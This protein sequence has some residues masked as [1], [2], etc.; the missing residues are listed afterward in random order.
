MT[1]PI[2]D[3][4]Q[5]AISSLAALF[6]YGALEADTQPIKFIEGVAKEIRRLRKKNKGLEKKLN[7]AISL[8][9]EVC[10]EGLVTFGADERMRKFLGWEEDKDSDT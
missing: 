4:L 7:R 3:E 8:I 6:E 5:K 2:T 9:E 10:G 1:K